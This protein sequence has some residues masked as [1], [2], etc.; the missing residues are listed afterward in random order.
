MVAPL[1]KNFTIYQGSTFN[2][3]LRWESPVKVYKTVTGIT[4]AAPMVISAPSH[5]LVAGWR[6]RLS[7][8]I[9]MKEVNSEEY[10]QATTVTTD[11][12]TINSVNAAGYTAY[13]SG[14]TLEY[15]QPESLSGY[16]ARMQIRSKISSADVL[17]ELTSANSRIII[18]DIAKTITINIPASVTE[19]LT[20]KT[21]VYSLELVSGTIVTPLI[22]GNLKLDTEITR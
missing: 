7:N 11:T 3:V 4:K 1:K 20:F 5:G 18:D 8:V 17:L 9:G 6:C 10:I 14:G 2:E 16:T 19:T 13:V 21:A 22:Y 15:N 12:I